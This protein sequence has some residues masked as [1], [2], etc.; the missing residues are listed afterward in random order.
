MEM[1]HELSPVQTDNLGITI[2]HVE[3]FQNYSWIQ[4]IEADFP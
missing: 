1:I 2:W 4:D 3:S